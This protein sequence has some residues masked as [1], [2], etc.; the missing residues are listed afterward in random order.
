MKTESKLTMIGPDS[1]PDAFPPVEYALEQPNGLLAAGGDLS[2]ERLLYAYGRGIF[3]WYERNEPILWWSPDPRMVLLPDEIHISKSLKRTLKSHRFETSWDTCPAAVLH[4]CAA[5]RRHGSETWLS[6]DMIRAYLKLAELGHMH[7]L[8]V[9][10][11]GAL[12]GGLYGISLGTAFFGESMFS[13][14][15]DAS[16]V[17]LVA[18]CER[19][20]SHPAALIDCQVPSNHLFRMGGRLWPRSRFSRALGRAVEHPDPWAPQRAQRKGTQDARQKR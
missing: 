18:L 4:A 14:R 11:H 7:S 2:T 20:R 19:Y 9:W 5:P 10:E 6:A 8:E 12:V 1:P 3:P 13:Y 15:S 17:A 16:K